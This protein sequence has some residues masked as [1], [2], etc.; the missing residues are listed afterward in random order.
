MILYFLGS[1]KVMELL[2]ENGGDVN[3]AGNSGKAPLHWAAANGFDKV[4]KILLENNANIT[5]GKGSVGTP[6][7]FAVRNGLYILQT[8]SDIIK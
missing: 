6:L 7:E 8:K 1:D 2:I 4:I 3:K 5:A